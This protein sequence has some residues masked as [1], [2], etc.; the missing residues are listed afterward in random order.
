M[1]FSMRKAVGEWF[2][3]M[4]LAGINGFMFYTEDT[5]D[6]PG[7]KMFGFL[8]GKL[9]IKELQKYDELG[10]K[11]GIELIP[12]IQAL[13]H[14]QRIL[15]F[16]CYGSIKDTDSVMLCESDETLKFIREDQSRQLSSLSVPRGYISA[17]TRRGI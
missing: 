2:R 5:Y 14:M 7:E 13:A 1:L 12:C 6:V 3:F 11:F 4:A 16:G 8:R 17:W 9:L 15:Q 10:A